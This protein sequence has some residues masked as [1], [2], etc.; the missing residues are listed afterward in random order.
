[1]GKCTKL[2]EAARNNPVG[3][4]FMELCALAECHGWAFV[5]QRGSHMLFKHA[6][7]PTR[8]TFQPRENGSAKVYQVRQ[9][10]EAIESTQPEED[11]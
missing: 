5:R 10:L 1:M 4:R 9:L 11:V 3:L 2:L 8:L 7:H 6:E